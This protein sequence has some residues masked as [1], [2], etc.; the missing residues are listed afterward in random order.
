MVEKMEVK[1]NN[2]VNMTVDGE[3]NLVKLT[4]ITLE[5]LDRALAIKDNYKKSMVVGKDGIILGVIIFEEIIKEINPS[6][7]S[8]GLLDVVRNKI[9]AYMNS[10]GYFI[11]R[12]INAGLYASLMMMSVYININMMNVDNV[13]GISN[14]KNKVR[15]REVK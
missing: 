3:V 14:N 15:L 8:D 10:K 5:L 9:E 2:E 12:D 13:F 1:L 6:E 11:D 4:D 7:I